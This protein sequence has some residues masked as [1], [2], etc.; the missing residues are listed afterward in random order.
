MSVDLGSEQTIK[1]YGTNDDI[2]MCN[3]PHIILVL[4]WLYT[5][6]A[7]WELLFAQ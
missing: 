6:T 1:K 5:S 7:R 4:V 2:L 3:S